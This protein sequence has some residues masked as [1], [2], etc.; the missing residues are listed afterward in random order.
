[1]KAIHLFA[2][3]IL[4]ADTTFSQRKSYN[5]EFKAGPQ[6]VGNVEVNGLADMRHFAG[7]LIEQDNQFYSIIDDRLYHA[8][9]L[10]SYTDILKEENYP[11]TQGQ[12]NSYFYK[13]GPEMAVV[14]LTK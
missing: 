9:K 5:F 1:M 6:H 14:R 8:N 12:R 7:F 3:L 2:F 10:Y 4:L 11:L 13:L